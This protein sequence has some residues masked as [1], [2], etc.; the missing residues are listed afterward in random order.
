MAIDEKTT[1]HQSCP[2]GPIWNQKRKLEVTL[3]FSEIIKLQFG[4]NG[5]QL[6]F[7]AF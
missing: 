2:A 4:E 3:H 5:I 6:H 1:R 7:K